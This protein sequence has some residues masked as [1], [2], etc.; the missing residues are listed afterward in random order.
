MNQLECRLTEL[1]EWADACLGE[2][3]TDYCKAAIERARQDG[4]LTL[5]V[6]V[7]GFETDLGGFRGD[8]LVYG[9]DDGDEAGTRLS[10]LCG[11][12]PSFG[13]S[14]GAC[15]AIG[16]GVGTSPKELVEFVQ[17]AVERYR[18]SQTETRQAGEAAKAADWR[19]TWSSAA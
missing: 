15:R 9:N 3:A 10:R 14:R 1:L 12:R 4:T 16:S 8:R 18:S 19:S 5:E 6:T 7:H 11:T 17:A 2:S 13:G